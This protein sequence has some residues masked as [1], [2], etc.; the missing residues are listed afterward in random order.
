MFLGYGACALAGC[1][2][3][4]GFY[5]GRLALD[6]MSVEYMV[7]YRFLF[8][9]LGMLPVALASRVRLTW[10]ET[11]L[12]LISAFFGIPVQFLV[13]FHGLARTTVS[14]ASLM[15]GSMPVLLGVAAALFA[16]E[17]LDRIGWLALAGSTVGAVLIV[18]G[19]HRGPA[20]HGEPSLT[21]DLMVVASLV[22]ALAWILLSK[23]L[24]M[25][26]SPS[27]VT[28]YTILLG[29]LMLAVWV[30]GPWLL[31]PWLPNH[32]QPPPF[33]HVSSTAW[34]A[35]AISGLACTATTTLL[36]NWGLNHVPASRAG[37]F[38]NIEPALGSVLGVK[39][40]GEH[41]GPYA[42]VGGALI[43]GTAVVLTTY[44]HEPK[45][46]VILE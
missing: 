38:L 27:V 8:A 10:P 45:A 44:G 4:T 42:W 2:W 29:T 33:A 5:F 22:T 39:L 40:L 36:W 37:V 17:R 46:D 15:V 23:K 20:A 18:L 7:L 31:S 24:M 9:C 25:T 16:G 26:H 3:G 41:L 35:L 13:Q 6:E 21:G 12:L 28:A 43:L 19:G 32:S 11:R 14:H 30:L 34:I 1:L